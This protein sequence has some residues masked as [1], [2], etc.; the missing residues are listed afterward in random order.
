MYIIRSPKRYAL[1]HFSKRTALDSIHNNTAL[2]LLEIAPTIIDRLNLMIPPTCG[3]ISPMS[4]LRTHPQ[5]TLIVCAFVALGLLY[6]LIIP[7]FEIGDE[8]R[9]Y[10]VI[11]YMADTGRLPV[12]DE[13]IVGEAK[14][15]WEHEGNQPPLYYAIAA[16]LT[17]WIDTG[18]WREVY[19]YNPHT[20]IG[21]P[22]RLDNKNITIHPPHEA[23]RGHVL[24]VHLIRFFSLTLA[25]IT[26]VT[27]YLIALALFQ[28][29][30]WLASA[31]LAVTAFNPMFI[32]ISAAVNNDNLVITC[33][34][35]ALWVMVRELEMRSK[36]LEVKVTVM[37]GLL[38]GLGTLS[39]LYAVGLIPL[40]V[41]WLAWQAYQAGQSRH[42]AIRQWL[43][44]CL[45]LGGVVAL[46]GGWFYLRNAWLYQGDVLALQSMRETA[47]MRRD[48]FTLATFM[49]E[50]EGLRIA[51]WGL[52]GGV[53]IL[54]SPW[55]YHVLDGLSLLAVI[56]CLSLVIGH[57]S[58]VNR[59]LLI[60]NRSATND[61]GQM[62]NDKQ[63]MTNNNQTMPL[64]LGWCL[65]MVAG[66]IAWNW[67]QPATQGRLFYPAISAISALMILGLSF[68]LRPLSF[69]AQLI[70]N[71]KRQKTRDY[72][73]LTSYFLLL[74]FLFL[75]ALSVPFIYLA[76]VYAKPPLLTEADLPADVQRVDLRYDNTMRLIGYQLPDETFHAT[77]K[78]PITLYW[79]LLQPTTQNYSIF[80][81]LLGRQRQT[82][83]QLDSYPGG[84]AWPTSLMPV[85][86]I[87]ADHYEVTLQPQA[88]SLAPS[89]LQVAVGI[90]DYYE[91]GR[92][93][94]PAVNAQGQTVDP[95]IS[96][97]KLS[98]WQW[99]QVTPMPQPVNF[100]DKVTLLHYDWNRPQAV[101]T[102]TW[103]VQQPL[104]AD[105][106]VFI[107]AWDSEFRQGFDAP[108]V[109]NDYPTS[110]WA[111]DEIIVDVH[112]L[113]SLPSNTHLL[114]GL[115]NPLTGERLSATQQG[116][117]LRDNAVVI[118]P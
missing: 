24:A 29:N 109:A 70:T 28:G 76:P 107:Q 58:I 32:F 10:A 35:L 36:K 54:M 85:G 49:A 43:T 80:I 73:L 74:A 117:L 65:I 13:A 55:I 104:G 102:L 12:Q 82:V 99:P 31:A 63:Q 46:I 8:S 38:I 19:W 7:P 9:H 116:Q 91:S 118:R 110:L 95:I 112:P 48:A 56:G 4:L 68:V 75:L 106:T 26:V 21:D 25:T 72:L 98:P 113:T 15:H 61:Q 67:T 1:T 64:L 45:I 69:V 30:R 96:R 88:E 111:K 40:A 23:W 44:H 60:V 41:G 20:S 114:I 103:Q 79:Q 78:L 100:A 83:G 90:Y 50:F 16:A 59:H 53:N 108:P 87:L 5:A 51:Y 97:R 86:A 62:T 2:Q 22:L 89:Q 81:H 11:K 57:L 84:G 47:G 77:E 93:G 101:L 52:F 6:S 115:Y 92:P 18:S 27:S 105:Y 94:R 33:V 37:V 14:R 17:V 42:T 3:I 39:K 34:T 71:D 66:F